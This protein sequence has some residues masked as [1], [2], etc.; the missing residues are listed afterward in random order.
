MQRRFASSEGLADVHTSPVG[1]VKIIKGRAD[2]LVDACGLW[3]FADEGPASDAIQRRA[4]VESL[5][6]R[7]L[8][9]WTRPPVH[10]LL[11]TANDDPVGTIFGKPR[12]D[13]PQTGQISLLA[14][15]P[16]WQRQGIGQMLLDA[17]LAALTADGCRRCRAYVVASAQDIHAFYEK[18]GWTFTAEVE[19][20]PDD[21]I[22][23]RVYVKE[24]DG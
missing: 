14:V 24:L 18:R 4:A 21:G 9:L 11:A 2:D 3:F 7:L 22:E 13:D 10:L 6:A 5:A 1:Q 16:A 12:R 20:S 17:A 8:E 15:H 23:E 19:P